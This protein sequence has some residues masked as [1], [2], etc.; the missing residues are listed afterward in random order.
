LS[1]DPLGELVD[2]YEEVSEALGRFSERPH[3]VEVPDG[4]RP[5]DGNGLERLRREVSLSS[6]ELAPFTMLYDVLG[7]R[8]HRGTVESLSESLSDKCSWTGVMTVGPG[9]YLP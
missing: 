1:L 3:H 2:R 8:H 6:V 5:R 4:E 7:V 9:V